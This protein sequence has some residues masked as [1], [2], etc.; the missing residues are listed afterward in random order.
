MK[1]FSNNYYYDGKEGRIKNR[2][3][4]KVKDAMLKIDM[5]DYVKRIKDNEK[6]RASWNERH[7]YEKV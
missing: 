5:K 1:D 6:N 3:S 7:G 4:K 2:L